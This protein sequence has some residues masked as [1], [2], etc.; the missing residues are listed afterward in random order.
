MK[1]HSRRERCCACLRSAE[2]VNRTL[3]QLTPK[4]PKYHEVE[5]RRPQIRGKLV[6]VG[7]EPNMNLAPQANLDF[8]P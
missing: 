7:F 6:A 8:A 5:V 3:S 4:H 1:S 2:E